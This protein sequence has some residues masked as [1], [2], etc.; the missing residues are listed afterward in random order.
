MPTCSA[1]SDLLSSLK[2]MSDSE[3]MEATDRSVDLSHFPLDVLAYIAN[4]ACSFIGGHSG[5]RRNS[6]KDQSAYVVYWI[7]DK[8][9]PSTPLYVGITKNLNIRW[10]EHRS[11]SKELAGIADINAI[12]IR[13]V[14]T[15]VGTL[16]DAEAVEIKHIKHAV[17]LNPS[18]LNR[19][20]N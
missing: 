3:F 9:D 1:D 12:T 7:V 18:L 19:R 14:D 2:R 15:I 11:G 5:V 20:R 16:P 8:S 17:S 13:V 6:R 10:R 4:R